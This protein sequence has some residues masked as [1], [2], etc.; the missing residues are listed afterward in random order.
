VRAP[1]APLYIMMLPTRAPIG[2]HGQ[3]AGRAVRPRSRRALQSLQPRSLRAHQAPPGPALPASA[4]QP[5][6]THALQHS[7]QSAAHGS[8][9]GKSRLEGRGGGGKFLRASARGF[10]LPAAAE[11]AGGRRSES[12][13]RCRRQGRRARA[14]A[15]TALP[16]EC[17]HPRRPARDSSRPAAAALLRVGSCAR[18]CCARGASAAAREEGG[19]P[20]APR[21]RRVT[22][23][24]RGVTARV[25]K[26]CLPPPPPPPP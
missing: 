24:S 20:R 7:I 18:P 12:A 1:Q 3:R 2:V 21:R 11:R 10:C 6:A 23:R 17:A 5:R 9:A 19:R 16:S 22:V 26:L 8:S 14:A 15:I 13:L 25:G 4:S